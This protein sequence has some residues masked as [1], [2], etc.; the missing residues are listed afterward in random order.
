[1]PPAPT[2]ALT[3]CVV[4]V[5]CVALLA[6]CGMLASDR[7]EKRL[8]LVIGNAAYI[9]AP[10]LKNPV[11]DAADMCAALQKV[12]FK[13]LCHTDVRSRE[14][15]D[16]HVK[17]YVDGLTP[18][19]VGV[20]YYSGHGV[21]V[22]GANYLIPTQVQPKSA[23]ENPLQV[24]YGIN[25]LYARLRERPTKFQLI[26]LDACRTDLFEP[27]PRASGN[28]SG[29]NPGAKSALVLSLE[30]FSRASSGLAAI[31]DAPVNTTV[32]YATAS[33]EAAF[34]GVGRNGPLTKHILRHI[35][36]KGVE[37][38]QF[39]SRVTAGVTNETERDYRLRQTPFSYGSFSG[40]FCFAGCPK[41]DVPPIQ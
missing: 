22:N 34:D 24:L 41:P 29:P 37:V 30:T 1:M 4:G 12:R 27:A 6:A 16:S 19:T 3:R 20:I 35:D 32:L 38:K 9:N 14:E 8:A 23:S 2:Q 5:T 40:E 31:T 21:Q 39:I 36:A 33:K 26:I 7:G 13:A 28:S 10:A 25:D 15:F 18:S 11:N 17:A